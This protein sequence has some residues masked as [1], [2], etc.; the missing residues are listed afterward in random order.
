MF[1]RED[2]FLSTIKI[3]TSSITQITITIVS[4]SIKISLLVWMMRCESKNLKTN[5][6]IKLIDVGTLAG[7]KG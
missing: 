4:I 7:V 1:S 5:V 2:T 3:I 6:I